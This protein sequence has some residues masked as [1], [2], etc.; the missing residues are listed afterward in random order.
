MSLADPITLQTPAANRKPPRAQR[1]SL[2]AIARQKVFGDAPIQRHNDAERRAIIGQAAIAFA[3]HRKDPNAPKITRA[4]RDVLYALIFKFGFVRTGA[5]FPSY[6][7]IAAAAHTAR[8]TV[9]EAIRQLED[10]GLLTWVNRLK[11]M[12]ARWTDIFGQER[13]ST[14]PA[15]ASNGYT[16]PKPALFPKSEKRTGP[17]TTS[18]SLPSKSADLTPIAC[19]IGL[20]EA[21]KRLGDNITRKFSG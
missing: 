15:R 16:F 2:A 1:R 10:A 18:V 20:N 11:R 21:L 14:V 4:T 13:T 5:C 12:R 19:P 3:A 8:S 9:A 7:S 17:K 6:E